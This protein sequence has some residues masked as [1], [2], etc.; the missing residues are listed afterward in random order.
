MS[1]L[2]PRLAIAG[3][4]LIGGSLALA[5]RAAGLVGEVVGY[6][7]SAENLR[8]ARERGVIDRV[9]RDPAA[10]VANADGL[11]LAAPLGACAGLA[12]AFRPHARPGTILTDVGS[13]KALLVPALEA[14]WAGIGPVVG[15]HPIAGSDASGAAAA[16]A[17]LFHGRRCILTPTGHTD[18][19]AL[20]RVRALWEGVGAHV[21]AMPAALHDEILARVSHLP[22]VVAYA[23]AAAVGD[24]Q[25]DG[26]RA[27]DYAGDGFRDTT[28]IAGSP[29]ALWCDVALANATALRAALAEFRAALDRLEALVAAGDAAGLEAALGAACEIR[30]HLGRGP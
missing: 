25:L 17:D 13:A 15:A 27:L 6:G 26:R 5:A 7:R 12:E 3:V 4:G 19:A 2:F 21:E 1:V 30:R 22:H 14:R 10:A 8:V 28:R 9:E 24:V 20:A 23:L 11:V 16:R 29:A 18:P